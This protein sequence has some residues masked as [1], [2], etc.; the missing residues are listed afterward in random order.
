MSRA[1]DH[2]LEEAKA[3]PAREMI[4]R[5]G[6]ERLHP[7]GE[8]MVGPCPM[9][10]GRDR[11]AINLRTHAYLCRKC[12]IRG[13]DNVALAQDILGL[14]F[15]RALSWLC[16]DLDAQ[17]DPVEVERRRARAAEADRKSREQAAAY[18]ERAIRD[19]Q[20]MW[21]RAEQTPRKM[22]A[23][24]LEARGF[25][26][27][28]LPELPEALRYLPDHPYVKKIDSELVTLHRGPAMLAGVLAPDGTVQAAHQT[29]IDP[30]PPHGK[31]SIEF[32]GQGYPAKL[33]R[34]TKKGGAIRLRSPA[35]FDTLVMA[36]GIETTLSAMV[37]DP[38]PNAAYWAGADLGNMAG[39]AKRGPGLRYAGIPDLTDRNAFLPPPW[40][41]TLIF[42]QD[43]DSDPQAT[44]HKLL[45][46]AR[47]AMAFLPGLRARIVPVDAGLDMNDVLRG[48]GAVRQG[49]EATDE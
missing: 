22:V 47:R 27:E 16:G 21:R 46:G 6:I 39:K 32:R 28:L 19:A 1:P 7:T 14:D 15:R 45:C 10:G 24:Y 43:G 25:S 12:D 35:G 41:K 23:A 20:A 11:F 36:E 38:L 9:C 34:G 18:R 42:V 31:A 37:A 8:E 29:W 26:R 5:L 44:R 2:R 33:M 13:G 3:I 17:I 48:E 30:D 40:I 4:S 49:Q